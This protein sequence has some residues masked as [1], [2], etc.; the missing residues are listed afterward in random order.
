[1]N[2]EQKVTQYRSFLLRL[3]QE[4]ETDLPAVWRGEI[5]WIQSG[6]TWRFDSLPI[7]FELFQSIMPGQA[8]PVARP[9][10]SE[11]ERFP[12]GSS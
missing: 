2:P 10:G 4:N 7:M 11:G 6:Q 12:C 1:M 3:W 5:E 9:D 8:H